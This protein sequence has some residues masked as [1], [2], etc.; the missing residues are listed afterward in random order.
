MSFED[1]LHLVQGEPLHP[2]QVCVGAC[3]LPAECE[4]VCACERQ[5]VI[6]CSVPPQT[7]RCSACLLPQL[8][9]MACVG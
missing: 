1:V 7:R 9:S 8:R 3:A 5:S 6:W 4:N 2:S